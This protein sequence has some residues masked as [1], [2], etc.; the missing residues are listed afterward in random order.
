M[1]EDYAL[2][3]KIEKAKFKKDAD[4]FGKMDPFCEVYVDDEKVLRTKTH[5]DAGKTPVWD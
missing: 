1:S 3:F 2:E 5:D 4:F